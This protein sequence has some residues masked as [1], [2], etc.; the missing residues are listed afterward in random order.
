MKPSPHSSRDFALKNGM[1]SGFQDV[2]FENSGEIILVY[3]PNNKA[4]GKGHAACDI[5]SD[6]FTWVELLCLNLL[7]RLYGNG[8]PH[9]MKNIK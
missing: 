1:V 4:T 2:N 7:H 5:Q 8:Q 9:T 6:R 3:P